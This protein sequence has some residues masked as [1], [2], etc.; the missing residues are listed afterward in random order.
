VCVPSQA[1]TIHA[2]YLPCCKTPLIGVLYDSSNLIC[3][4]HD[5][6]ACLT[7]TVRASRKV[8]MYGSVCISCTCTVQVL[9]KCMC[10]RESPG[11]VYVRVHLRCVC[12]CT[13]VCVN[14]CCYN[15]C[16]STEHT[17]HK[18]KTSAYVSIRQHSSAY[19]C[20]IYRCAC[21]VAF[22]DAL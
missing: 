10:V 5:A 20:S 18:C 13:S 16:M 15:C 8:Y 6:S 7:M 9:C 11:L 3:V 14:P 4:M 22:W 21:F 12:A 2:Y 1:L 17:T 19:T